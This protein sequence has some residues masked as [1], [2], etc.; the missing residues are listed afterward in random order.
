MGLFRHS[1]RQR[2]ERSKTIYAR[3]QL[4]YTAVDFA[5]SLA[6]VAGSVMYMLNVSETTVIWTY[7]VGSVLFAT[8]PTLRISREIKLYHMGHV[9]HLAQK[10]EP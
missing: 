10:A 8:K 6:F 5:A 7:L 9:D 3:F 1:N 4:A 2:T